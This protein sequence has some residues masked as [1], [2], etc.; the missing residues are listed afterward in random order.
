MPNPVPRMSI[1][2]VSRRAPAPARRALPFAVAAVCLLP[3]ATVRAATSPGGQ[4]IPTSAST[5][6]MPAEDGYRLWLRYVPVRG[7]WLSRYRA[8]AGELVGTAPNASAAPAAEISSPSPTLRAVQAE[9]LRGL[10]GLLGTRPR[11]AGDVTEN[12]AMLFGTPRSSALV[13]RLGLDLRPAGAEGYLIRTVTIH[14]HRATVIAAN[15]DI[16]VL[17]GAFGFLRLLQTRAPI[18]HVD[19]TAQPEDP[20]P[21]ARSLGQPRTARSS[22]ATRAIPS[23]SG[24]ALPEHLSP[25]YTDYARACASIGINGMVLNNVNATPFILTPLYLR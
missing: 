10:T 2:Q 1:R 20:A 8:S 15:S 18:D 19:I 9:L 11:V 21:R 3:A 16:G 14:G 7:E 23:G 13:R 25:R 4:A 5:A 6:I 22:A 17:Y 12:G 24:R